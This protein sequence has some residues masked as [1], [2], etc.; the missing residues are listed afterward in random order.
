MQNQTITWDENEIAQGRA[1][2][3]LDAKIAETENEAFE[4]AITDSDW[5]EWE[6]EDFKDQ[7]KSILDDISPEGRFYVEGRNMGWR[8]LSGHA[9]I[10]ASSAENYM[11]KAF[12]KTS[13][14]TFQG[15]YDAAKKALE[16][17]LY[18]HDSPT[19]E[20]YSVY[21]SPHSIT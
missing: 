11:E 5:M 14:W 19:G 4:M 6:F 2:E 13:E 8:R 10:E 15:S 21:A 1:R 17:R 16:Y 12:P 7:L 3:F 9:E 20:I 18:H